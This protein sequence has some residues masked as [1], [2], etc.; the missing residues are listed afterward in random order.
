MVKQFLKGQKDEVSAEKAAALKKRAFEKYGYRSGQSG[1]SSQAGG[2]S[3]SGMTPLPGGL[4]DV[5]EVDDDMEEYDDD[6]DTKTIRGSD[7]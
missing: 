5:I 3:E 1:G 7:N 4:G 6:D 2:S